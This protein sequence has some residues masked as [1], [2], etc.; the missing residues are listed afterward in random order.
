LGI[1]LRYL[2]P[3]Y[4][5]GGKLIGVD[6]ERA[7]A[8]KVGTSDAYQQSCRGGRGLAGD[9]GKFTGCGGIVEIDAFCGTDIDMSNRGRGRGWC[10]REGK[11][12]NK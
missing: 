5:G 1:D 8:D 2:L 11:C 12:G 4:S 9:K 7:Q 10:L 6:D 3:N